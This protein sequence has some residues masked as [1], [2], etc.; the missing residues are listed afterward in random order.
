MSVQVP[1]ALRVQNSGVFYALVVVALTF[2]ILTTSTGHRGYV[3]FR[4]VVN[5]LDQASMTAVLVVFMTV[6]LIS[7]NFDLSVASTAALSAEIALHLVGGHSLVVVILACLV[8]G[9]GVGLV[10][11]VLV[12]YVGVNAFIV[13]LATMAAVRGV[14]F[15]ASD[16][17]SVTADTGA[18]RAMTIGRVPVNG[19]TVGIVVAV[20]LAGIALAWIRNGRRGLPTWILVGMA[21]LLGVLSVL[22][23]PAYV[24][25][26]NSVII[27]FA[28][29]IVVWL[30]LT[31]T[32]VGRRLHAVG[33]N[34]EAARLSG[35]AVNRYRV[36]AFVASG[37]AAAFVGL[38]FAGRYESMNPQAL[39]GEELVILTAAILGGTSLF[40]GVGNVLKS[41]LGAL[42]L[43]ALSNGMNFQ[44]INSAWQGVIEGVVL[45]LAAGAYTVASQRRARPA[46]AGPAR[47]TDPATA[48]NG[49]TGESVLV[50]VPGR[51]SGS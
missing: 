16:G 3:S 25:V 24:V 35:I 46:T 2:G 45:V 13:T 40:G 18:L 39:S 38:M 42:I 29:T 11:G 36:T 31:Y 8:M 33:S 15:L 48:E 4:N 51:V 12:Q 5:V 7:G 27:M 6:V 47:S 14:V 44:Q 10:N 34:D 26:T 30:V 23:F 21:V 20:V 37:V 43:A 17:T 1:N 50:D 32:I 28:I 9:A 19:K 49:K 41:V 22:F